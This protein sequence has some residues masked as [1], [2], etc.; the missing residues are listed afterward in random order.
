VKYNATRKGI[1]Q[2]F[3][4]RMTRAHATVSKP[5]GL[6]NEPDQYQSK[7]VF[8]PAERT[9]GWHEINQMGG[10]QRRPNGATYHYNG[11][12]RRS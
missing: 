1:P 12:G 2:S 7:A 4:A 8:Q 11:D 9:D 10:F 6:S 5:V 3:R